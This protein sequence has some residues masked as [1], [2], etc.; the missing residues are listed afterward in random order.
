MGLGGGCDGA[1]G[2]AVVVVVWAWDSR[3][4]DRKSISLLGLL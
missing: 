2:T 3:Q 4:K 1:G